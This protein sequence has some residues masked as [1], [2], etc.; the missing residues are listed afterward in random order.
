LTRHVYRWSPTRERG[1]DNIH[2]INERM[3]MH[4]HMEA[5]QFYYNLIR[6]FD[7]SDV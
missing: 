3:N 6:N 5:V 2:T 7:A 4:A 1:N